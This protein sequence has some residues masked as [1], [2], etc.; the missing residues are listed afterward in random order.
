MLSFWSGRKITCKCIENIDSDSR[1]VGSGPREQ[2]VL[3]PGPLQKARFPDEI[4]WKTNGKH[5]SS[6]SSFFFDVF[7]NAFCIGL[8]YAFFFADGNRPIHLMKNS[9][10]HLHS[11][12]ATISKHIE[13]L[14]CFRQNSE[15]SIVRSDLIGYSSYMDRTGQC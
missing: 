12:L 9:I 3:L 8:V 10:S 6:T 13:N 15:F 7:L 1:L 4:Q 2:P 11:P 5:C 14:I